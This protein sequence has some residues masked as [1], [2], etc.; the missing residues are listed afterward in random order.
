MK[1]FLEAHESKIKG[2]LS[3]FDRMIFRGYLPIQDG[4][5]MARFLGRGDVR[6]CDLKTFLLEHSEKVKAHGQELARKANR[7]YKYLKN[8]AAKMESQAREMA[9]RDGID[10]GLV[11]VFSKVE[12]CRTFSFRFQKGKPFVKPARR[13]CLWLYLYFIDRTLGLIHVKLQTWFP[14]VMQVYVNG[15]EWL[16]RKLKDS[17]IGFTKVDNVFVDVANLQRAQAFA[18]RF[19]SVDWPALLDPYARQVNPLM[20]N[21]LHEQ[22][23]YWVTSQ[24]EYATDVLFKSRNA[25]SELYPRF[26]S[27][28]MQ[29]FG[30]KDVMSFLG[31]KLHGKFE[32]EIITDL[33]DLARYRIAGVRVKHR[34]KENWLKMYDKAGLVLRIETVINNPEEFRVRKVV[35]RSGNKTTEWVQMRKGVQYL[36]RYRD[37]SMSANSRYLDALAVVSDPTAKVRE[38]D[39]ITRRR[40]TRSGRSAKAINPLAREDLQLFEAVMDGAHCIRGFTNRDLRDKLAATTHLR[41]FRDDVRRQ[42]SKVTRILRRLHLHKIV[43]KIPRSRKWRVTAL[44]RRLMA[45]ALQ[46]RHLN[47]PQLLAL[48]T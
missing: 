27:H 44:G 20:G 2:V 24:S 4:A 5:E 31:R 21:I 33:L 38:L 26:V 45:T 16:A 28:S 1:T 12:P 8:G 14:M 41:P 43:A 3:C 15:H 37:V 32:G 29:C 17:G 19:S 30:A 23:Y 42:S 11:C 6:F 46:L 9:A 34:V 18:D 7:P 47:F 10:E 25:L 40:Q 35:T 22:S 36:F 48:S 39:Q 13:K